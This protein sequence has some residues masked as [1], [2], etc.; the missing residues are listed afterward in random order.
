MSMLT[1]NGIVQ[2]VFAK[3]TSTDKATGE[4]R[5]ASEHAQILAENILET[6]EKRL[7]MVTLKVHQG[8]AFRNLVGQFVR[9]PVGAFVANGQIQYYSL[10]NEAMPISGKAAAQ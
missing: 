10:K 9:V 1:L 2:N 7:D 6:G 5:P 4:I 3:P 8:E